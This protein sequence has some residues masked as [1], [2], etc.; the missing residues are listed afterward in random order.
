M[1]IDTVR[2]FLAE[3][4]PDI[5]I[6]E[7][8]GSFPTVLQGAA[9]GVEP[10]Q[11]AKT[12]SLRLGDRVVLLVTRGDAR[13]NNKKVKAALALQPPNRLRAAFARSLGLRSA[14][15]SGLQRLR[16]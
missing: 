15:P 2:T 4:A 10:A 13:L 8:E 14:C 1:T 16:Q 5:A 12:L 6:I 9:H 7:T 3:H 11:I